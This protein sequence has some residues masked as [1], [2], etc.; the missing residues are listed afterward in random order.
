MSVQPVDTTSQTNLHAVVER[1][2]IVYE[3]WPHLDVVEHQVVKNGYIVEIY[4]THERGW[5]R[6]APGSPECVTTYRNM[7]RIVE[8]LAPADGTAVEVEPYSPALYETA[9]RGFRPEVRLLL[10]AV[11]LNSSAPPEEWLRACEQRLGA[12][13]ARRAN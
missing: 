6:L 12:I 13:G 4:G 2:S 10:V 9:S 7:L 3:V 8:S 5:S 11:R 1:H